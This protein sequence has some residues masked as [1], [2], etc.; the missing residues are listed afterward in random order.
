MQGEFCRFA[1]FWRCAEKHA[2]VL[3]IFTKNKGKRRGVPPLSCPERRCFICLCRAAAAG[4]LHV[5]RIR[6]KNIAG[7][8]DRLSKNCVFCGDPPS[9]CPLCTLSA[10]SLCTLSARSLHPLCARSAS[11][12]LSVYLLSSP[13]KKTPPPAYTRA[14]HRCRRG[15]HR[16]ARGTSPPPV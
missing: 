14:A 5:V 6:P 15:L 8:P 12:T 9:L 3:R 10:R 1:H 13:P 7:K 16:A 2:F 4:H 11:C